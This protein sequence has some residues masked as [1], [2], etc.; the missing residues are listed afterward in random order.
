M[1]PWRE[2]P[3][4]FRIDVPEYVI[5]HWLPRT[6]QIAHIKPLDLMPLIHHFGVELVGKKVMGLT[7]SEP[8]LDALNPG[9]EQ[10]RRRIRAL[11]TVLGHDCR[12]RD[13]C[14]ISNGA[15]ISAGFSR[16]RT[17]EA[18]SW[19]W[20]IETVVFSGQPRVAQG[21]IISSSEEPERRG[22]NQGRFLF[23]KFSKRSSF[24]N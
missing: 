21:P 6:N 3:A 8:V 23:S 11:E 10:D 14:L 22:K 18:E 20:K 13:R 16:G 12:V 15:I 4:A 9:T 2:K 1:A 24:P 7:D 17:N 5:E 19:C